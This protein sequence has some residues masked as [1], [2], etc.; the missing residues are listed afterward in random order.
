MDKSTLYIAIVGGI[1]VAFGVFSLFFSGTYAQ[2]RFN[3][4]NKLFENRHAKEIDTQIEGRLSHLEQENVR[5]NH[6]LITLE[7]QVAKVTQ[8]NE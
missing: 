3:P 8:R 4:D 1:I 7:H 6:A 5:L 2:R